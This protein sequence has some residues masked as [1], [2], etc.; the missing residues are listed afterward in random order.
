LDFHIAYYVGLLSAQDSSAFFHIVSRDTGFDPLIKH[1]KSR[2]VFAQRSASIA[3]IPCF[4]PSLPSTNDAQIEAIVSHLIRLKAAK[5]RGQKTLLS[6]MHA[7]FKKELSEHQL[8]ALLATL[9]K[10]GIVKFDG[11]KVSYELPHGR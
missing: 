2:G 5:P 11:A 3:S 10:R 6:T 9:C 4:K 7:L 8:S 1:L